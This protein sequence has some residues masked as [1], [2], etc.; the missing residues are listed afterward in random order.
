M[1]RSCLWHVSE[2]GTG[3]K[4]KFKFLPCPSGLI[5]ERP[6]GLSCVV[7]GAGSECDEPLKCKG[8]G[9]VYSGPA[10]LLFVWLLNLCGVYVYV[11]SVVLR[12]GK[13]SEIWG[14]RALVADGQ[15]LSTEQGSLGSLL[16]FV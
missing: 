4:T 11:M 1:S 15:C 7:S 13:C 12:V 5:F 8:R 3:F 6:G 10:V 16:L 9:S 14:S 2:V